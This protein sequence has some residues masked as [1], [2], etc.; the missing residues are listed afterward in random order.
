MPSSVSS[1]ATEYALWLFIYSPFRSSL[2]LDIS[3]F[4]IYL[5]FEGIRRD[6][7]QLNL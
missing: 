7:L 2:T 5:P 3:F 4:H 1:K 6:V